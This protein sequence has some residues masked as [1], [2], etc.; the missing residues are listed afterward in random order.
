[1]DLRIEMQRATTFATQVSF[2]FNSIIG[3]FFG[4][5]Q[6]QCCWILKQEHS[7]VES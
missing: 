5:I 6:T 1:M 3:L 7:A 4:L 2:L